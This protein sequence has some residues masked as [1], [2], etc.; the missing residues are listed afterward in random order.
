MLSVKKNTPVRNIVVKRNSPKPTPILSRAQITR[1]VVLIINL[2]T[3]YYLVG[4]TRSL[5]QSAARQLRNKFLEYADN[6]MNII[7]PFSPW[8]KDI[9][10]LGTAVV[11]T[12]AAKLSRGTL[13][14]DI[15]NLA[16]GTS[17]FIAARRG[18][19]NISSLRNQFKNRNS[20][21]LSKFRFS[22]NAE[23]TRKL[24]VVMIAYLISTLRVFAAQN[25][26]DIVKNELTRRGITGT[27]KEQF[28]NY[29]R[30]LLLQL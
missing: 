2:I 5:N 21:F 28:L 29:G 9:R 6:F 14:L 26:A 20:S 16:V 24:I 1:I 13:K 18:F 30:V 11:H 17:S 7:S 12:I 22:N 3:I 25:V 4:Y 27:K 10:A 23:N 8:E 19:T 15:T